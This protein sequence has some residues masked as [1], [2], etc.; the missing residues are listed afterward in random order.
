MAGSRTAA[1]ADS[2]K[3]PTSRPGRAYTD[4][5]TAMSSLSAS[6]TS[7]ASR[8]SPRTYPSQASAHRRAERGGRCASIFSMAA[9]SAR[10]FW[11]AGTEPGVRSP[12]SDSA[13]SCSSAMRSA[14]AVSRPSSSERAITSSAVAYE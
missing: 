12:V 4:A 9:P 6:R 14:R 13:R 5:C 1:R 10:R 8:Q 11:P 2:R 7:L 3:G